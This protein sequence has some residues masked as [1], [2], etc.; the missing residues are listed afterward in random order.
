MSKYVYA[1]LACAVGMGLCSAQAQEAATAGGDVTADEAS[2]LPP[3]VVTSP[4]EPISKIGEEE[5]DDVE[6][7]GRPRCRARRKCGTESAQSSGPATGTGVGGEGPVGIFTLGQLDVIG[8]STITN[9]AMWTF[10]KNTLDQA[11]SIV[12]GVTMHNTGGSRNERDIFVR[13]F[14]RFRVPLSSTACASIC[15]PTT[16]STSTAS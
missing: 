4:A 14:D 16:D 12:P 5:D 7:V 3:I 13:G 15:P 6:P 10:N 8:G 9:E 11:A 2:P 1:A